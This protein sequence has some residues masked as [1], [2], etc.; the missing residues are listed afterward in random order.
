MSSHQPTPF[1]DHFRIETPE[2][3]Q[4]QFEIAGVGSRFL[5]L[6]LDTL[7][8]A[9]AVVIVVLVLI[10]AGL[11][12]ILSKFRQ[13]SLW[14]AAVIVLALFLLHF[15][16]FAW[17]EI[18]WNGQTPGKRRVGIRVLKDSGRPLTAF[19]A[20]GRNLL[21]IIDQLP[22]F[23]GVAVVTAVLNAESKRLGDFLAG[24]IVIHEPLVGEAQK[25]WERP[26]ASTAAGAPLGGK[27]LSA[28]DIA[29]IEAFLARRYQLADD[30][31]RRMAGEILSRMESKLTVGDDDRSGVEATLEALVHEHRA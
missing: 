11:P 16:Y 8:Q 12:G 4:L 10:A 17:F 14:M 24:S 19:E 23:Y 2:Q 30:V 3:I 5:A 15:G 22:G 29:L 20:I 31:R 7:I 6:A 25:S 27:R 1:A 13:S 26:P 28:E 9:I 21:R 18:A